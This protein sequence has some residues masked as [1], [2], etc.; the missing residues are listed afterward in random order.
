MCKCGLRKRR[1]VSEPIPTYPIQD[2]S[3]SGKRVIIGAKE[4]VTFEDP[5]RGVVTLAAG[6]TT[7][8]VEVEADR[9]I[10]EGVPIWKMSS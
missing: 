5:S 1:Q 2:T 10:G 6:Q 3:D 8:L 7:L 4:V 9:L